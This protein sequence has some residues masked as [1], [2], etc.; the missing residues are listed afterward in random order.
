MSS[1]PSVLNN[2]AMVHHA[3]EK[4]AGSGSLRVERSDSQLVDLVLAGDHDAFEEIFDRH[5]RLVALIARRYF[6]RPEEIEEI[7]QISFAKAYSEL[8]KFRGVH[9]RSLPSWL[10]RITSNACFDNLRGQR[11]KPERL[12]C[13]LSDVEEDALLN[14]ASGNSNDAENSIVNGD[15]VDK[16]L[17]SLPA[18]DRVLLRM[19]YA[20]EM[21]VADIADALGWTRSN[22]KIKAWRARQAL[23]KV[24][25]KYL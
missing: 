20:E 14:L 11:R 12:A 21:C 9:E 7:I 4:S 1:F 16:L 3:D 15:L 17:S 19:I 13:E 18:E 23:K 22:V 24:L 2:E 5:K 25:R 8:G 10:V 6:R